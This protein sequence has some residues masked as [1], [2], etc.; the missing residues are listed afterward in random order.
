MNANFT[1]GIDT[2][3]VLNLKHL[4]TVLALTI[5]VI[6]V[7]QKVMKQT[8]VIYDKS[9]NETGRGEIK[10]SLGLKKKTT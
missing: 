5:I 3:K 7:V 6:L 2:G 10:F 1:P 9:G 8:I 4:L